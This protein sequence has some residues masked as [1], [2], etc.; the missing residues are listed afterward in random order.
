MLRNVD[1]Y[2][3][4]ALASRI[5]YHAIKEAFTFGVGADCG[6]PIMLQ[7]FLRVVRLTEEFT[8]RALVRVEK[9]LIYA[10]NTM[11]H[12]YRL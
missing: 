2:F 7:I 12:G 4:G 8:A 10:R 11:T 3:S 1:V 6:S 9:T 5:A